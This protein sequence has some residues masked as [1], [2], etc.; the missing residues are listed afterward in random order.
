MNYIQIETG[1]YPLTLQH[2]KDENPNT[3]FPPEFTEAAGYARVQPVAKPAYDPIKQKCRE[4]A[5]VMAVDGV[6]QQTWVVVNLSQEAANANQQAADSR[7]ASSVRAER[8]RRLAQCDWTQV[9]DA[10]VNKQTWAAY[11]QSLRDITKQPGFPH[12]VAWPTQPSQ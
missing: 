4:G 2:L 6:W 9:A 7:A 5:P 8:D 11:R 3:S 1:R 12:N 10:Q